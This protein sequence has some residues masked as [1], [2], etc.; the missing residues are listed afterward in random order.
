MTGPRPAGPAWTTEDDRKL[1]AMLEAGMDK[2]LIAR[3]LKRTLAAIISRRGKLRQL[4]R[5]R[6]NAREDR[7]G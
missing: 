7:R 5:L 4:E 6:N 1:L 2:Q 3:K